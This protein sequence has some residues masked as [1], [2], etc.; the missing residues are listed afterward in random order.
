LGEEGTILGDLLERR[1]KHGLKTPILEAAFVSLS[2]YQPER[3][4]V[5]TD[6]N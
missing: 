2:I 3:E 4:V 6:L 1:P 5:S